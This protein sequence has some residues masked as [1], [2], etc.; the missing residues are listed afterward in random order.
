MEYQ[1]PI[2]H[3]WSTEEIIDVIRFYEH[4]EKAYEKGIV[5]K[6]LMTAYRRF[7][8]I[9]PSKSEEK[10][11]CH[12]FEELSSYSPYRTVQKA[13]AAQDGDLIKM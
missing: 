9:V 1:Y 12:E 3:E 7:K 6:H 2:S 4:I 5:R 11:L 13:K 10:Q 8:E